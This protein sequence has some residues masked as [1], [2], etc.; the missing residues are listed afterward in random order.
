MVKVLMNLMLIGMPM[1]VTADDIDEGGASK[2]IKLDSAPLMPEDQW[3]ATHPVCKR[4][5]QM[6]LDLVVLCS[7]LS[8]VVYNWPRFVYFKHYTIIFQV[9]VTV[10]IAVPMSSEYAQWNF[11]G[12]VLSFTGDV[13]TPISRIKDF[14]QESLGMPQ[15]K[16]KLQ[17]NG[18]FA[19]VCVNR[20]TL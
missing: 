14:I 16:Q 19:K 11:N 3:A 5:Y 8:I 13:R 9:P 10:S 4:V 17:L 7:I 20:K 6:I 2:R 18:A 15:G 12:Q 1:S